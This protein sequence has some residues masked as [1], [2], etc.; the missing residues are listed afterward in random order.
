MKLWLRECWRSGGRS[1]GRG[2]G[3]QAGKQTN[4]CQIKPI[5]RRYERSINTL[6]ETERERER[7]TARACKQIRCRLVAEARPKQCGVGNESRGSSRTM[8]HAHTHTQSPSSHTHTCAQLRHTNWIFLLL[9]AWKQTHAAAKLLSKWDMW[10]AVCGRVC[11]GCVCVC[12]LQI[13]CA[14]C[15]SVFMPKSFGMPRIRSIASARHQHQPTPTL[16]GHSSHIC[17]VP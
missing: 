12:M 5:A 9:L 6:I 3:R 8:Q 1:V 10:V 17:K 16:H 11:V 7:G 13:L 2:R 15:G 4:R 14:L